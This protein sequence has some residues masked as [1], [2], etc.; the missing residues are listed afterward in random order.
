[1]PR[2]LSY[3]PLD[4]D[5]FGYD[6]LP[7]ELDSETALTATAGSDYPDGLLQLAQI[8]RSARSGD[9]I[10]SA[11]PGYDL[12]EQYERPEHRSSHGA[13]H[14]AHMNVPLAISLPI[15]D[16]PVRTADVFSMVLEHLQIAEPAG[17]DGRSRL[18]SAAQSSA[19]AAAPAPRE[20]R[21]RSKTP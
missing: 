11:A 9:V 6:A 16:G 13:L 2:G 1:V 10:V 20:R 19:A 21:V 14:A 5:P 4:G 15:E 18:I 8:F 12:R 7:P 17:V 3:R